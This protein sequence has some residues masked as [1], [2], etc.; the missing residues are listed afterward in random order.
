M[1]QRSAEWMIG[2]LMAFV[3]GVL[4]IVLGFAFLPAGS[5]AYEDGTFV[6]WLLAWGMIWTAVVA[7]FAL[8]GFL[9][10][11]GRRN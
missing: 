5:K 7:A 3:L 8:T 10:V 2:A 4:S 6:P 9:V 1:S 11:T